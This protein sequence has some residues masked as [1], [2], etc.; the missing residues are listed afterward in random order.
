[1]AGRR[2]KDNGPPPMNTWHNIVPAIVVPDALPVHACEGLRPLLH[3]SRYARYH[4]LN[5]G[6]MTAPAARTIRGKGRVRAW[7]ST[8]PR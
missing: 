1:M 5:A 6:R 3:A 2:R 7:R 8:T 4:W